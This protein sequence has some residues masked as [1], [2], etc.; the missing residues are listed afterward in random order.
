MKFTELENLSTLLLIHLCKSV[1]GNEKI[2]T[3]LKIYFESKS[4]DFLIE[5][6]SRPVELWHNTTIF[7]SRTFSKVFKKPSYTIVPSTH[8]MNYLEQKS[9]Q[10][11]STFFDFYTSHF[12]RKL[13]THWAKKFANL[14][15]LR[16]LTLNKVRDN[17]SDFRYES[18][19]IFV[20]GVGFFFFRQISTF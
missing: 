3:F 5:F 20:L 16:E 9:S 2:H 12:E 15:N 17:C 19:G 1:W 14:A 4:F 11:F 6:E 7:F 8:F 10:H 13:L 18:N